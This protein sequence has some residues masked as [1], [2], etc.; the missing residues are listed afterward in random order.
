MIPKLT[1]QYK[2]IA[3]PL[4][5]CH[6]NCQDT[7]C[8]TI[9]FPF[10]LSSLLQNTLL[11]NDI[12]DAAFMHIVDLSACFSLLFANGFPTILTLCPLENYLKTPL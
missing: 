7:H 8:P 12:V 11:R 5:V 3:V 6:V 10:S 1:L 2:N 4:C 9:A